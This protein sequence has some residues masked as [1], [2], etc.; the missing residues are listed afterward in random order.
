MICC[1]LCEEIRSKRYTYAKIA[2]QTSIYSF[3]Q[4]N[5]GNFFFN[6]CFCYIDIQ[7]VLMKM[8]VA[9]C[10]AIKKNNKFYWL[11]IYINV[12]WMIHSMCDDFTFITETTCNNKKK[13]KKTKNWFRLWWLLTCDA[14]IYL[15]VCLLTWLLYFNMQINHHTVKIILCSFNLSLSFSFYF[16]IYFTFWLIYFNIQIIKSLSFLSL[17]LNCLL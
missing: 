11:I 8:K 10:K 3:H 4:L 16:S 5:D 9:I 7:N 14:N 6:W 17:S 2:A 1:V 12:N 13:I 15:P